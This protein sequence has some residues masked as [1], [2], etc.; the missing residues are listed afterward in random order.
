MSTSSDMQSLMN[1]YGIVG[2]NEALRE[3]LATAVLVAPTDL[4]VLIQGESGVGKE[5]IPRIIH[6][7]S[8]RR[9]KTYIAINCGSIPEGTIDSELFGHEKGAFTSAI[10]EHEG[11]FGAADGG[12]L[13]L[14]EVGELPMSTQARLLRVLETGEYLRVGSSTPR[15]TDVRIVAATNVD[16]PNAIKQGRFREDLYYRLCTINIKIP[17]LRKRDGDAVLLFKKFALDTASRYNIPEPI[18]LTPEAEAVVSSYKWPGNIRQLRNI[19]E[20]LSILSESRSIT[21]EVLAKHGITPNSDDDTGIATIGGG[22]G[23]ASQHDYEQEIK[24]LAHAVFEL[25]SEVQELKEKLHGGSHW[26]EA[27]ATTTL[28]MP[29]PQQGNANATASNF[30]SFTKEKPTPAVALDIPTAEEIID[31][32]TLNIGDMEKRNILLALQ[33]NHYKRKLAAEELGISERT[34]YRKIKAYG[35]DE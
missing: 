30:H 31:D 10:G 6:D 35:I 24:I 23:S 14:D 11:Y 29:I 34:L 32:D 17:P 4:S 22:S 26:H 21:P 16:I 5:V 7:H 27:T 3:A 33:R 18:R 8:K 15:R 12:T 19:T 1:R 25:R 28:P 20:Q 13:F 9:G 2:R